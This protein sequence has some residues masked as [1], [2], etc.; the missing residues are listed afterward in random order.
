MYYESLRI[1]WMCKLNK[2]SIA[3]QRIFNDTQ[4]ILLVRRCNERSWRKAQS[5]PTHLGNW[6][7]R[8]ITTRG[9][10][11]Y[12]QQHQ[13]QEEEQQQCIGVRAYLTRH[14]V[15]TLDTSR[16]HGATNRG[17][18]TKR[19]IFLKCTLQQSTRVLFASDVP[20]PGTP[21]G[22]PVRRIAN[23]AHTTQIHIYR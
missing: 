8:R 18:P 17:P 10:A 5:S 1:Q 14:V 23:L 2:K 4:C 3:S 16:S 13:Q 21:A 7:N 20:R 6:R 19:L 22:L 9:T 12:Q 15:T 11:Q